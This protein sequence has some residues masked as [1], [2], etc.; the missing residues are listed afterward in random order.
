MA[1][2]REFSAIITRMHRVD[3]SKNV[4]PNPMSGSGASS[5]MVDLTEKLTFVREELLGPFRI[6][7]LAKEWCVSPFSPTRLAS[8]ADRGR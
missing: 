7:D 4:D 6:G 5:Y 3:Y 8:R 1:I 2:R